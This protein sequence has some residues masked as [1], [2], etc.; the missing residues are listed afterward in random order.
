MTTPFLRLD[1]Q[2]HER[3]WG[4]GRLGRGPGGPI[5]E[6]W[7]LHDACRVADGRHA[8]RTLADVCLAEPALLG[9]VRGA[10]DARV[11]LL[12]KL[13]EAVD[14]LSVQ[15]HPN[16]AQ[17]VRLA[18]PGQQGKTEA[19]HVLEAA[20]GAEVI[21]GLKPGVTGRD[22]AAAMR[23]GGDLLGLIERLPVA[24]GDTIFNPT[25]LL[26]AL[27][28]G[29]L[30]YEVQQ[31]SDITYRAYDWDRPR[32]AGRALHVEEVLAVADVAA[33]PVVTP[34]PTGPGRHRLTACPFF[35]LDLLATDRPTDLGGAGTFQAVTLVEG[36]LA[37]EAAGRRARLGRHETVFV[38]AG[39][40]ACRLVPDGPC[41]VLIAAPGG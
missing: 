37:L 5:G 22:F 9:R 11:P 24:P 16:D 32:S 15:V 18:G 33:R 20:P 1:P 10:G 27:G 21:S 2:L 26:H 30:I 31:S 29:L 36:A 6:A 8:G 39:A 3:V 23:R 12:V 13:L 7:L 40:E 41:R 14:W 25:G 28:P 17:A 38:A 35:W 4:G 34:A 19:W